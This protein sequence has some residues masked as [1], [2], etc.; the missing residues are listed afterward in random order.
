MPGA[1]QV[2]F[3]GLTGGIGSGK[4][5]ALALLEELGATT[6]SADAVVHELLSSDDVRDALVSR[7]GGD[8]LDAD[9][10]VDRRAVAATVF[11]RSDDRAWLEGMLWPR[12][13]ARIVEWRAEADR[14]EPPPTAA[15]VEVPLLLEAGMEAVFDTTIA[16]GADEPLRV[17]RAEERGHAAVAE[18]SARQLPQQ[19]KAARAG[20]VVRN[21]GTRE[22]LKA[23]L[24]RVLATIKE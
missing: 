8:V 2:P 4:S 1:G 7:L 13:G 24:S 5:T 20:H 3:V 6:L 12:V 19:E 18:R 21:D 16:V 15:V 17:R 11:E 23:E 10:M 9:G 14:L 22:E